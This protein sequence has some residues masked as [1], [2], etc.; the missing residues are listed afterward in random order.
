ML[1]ITSQ[2]HLRDIGVPE[3]TI[4]GWLRDEEQ[5]RDFVDTVDITDITFEAKIAYIYIYIYIYVY[6]TF[7]HIHNV[8]WFT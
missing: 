7:L 3:T 5:L 2:Q 6:M 8:L 1:E 4:H